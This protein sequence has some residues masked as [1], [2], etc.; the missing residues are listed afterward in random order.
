[1]SRRTR[2]DPGL[3]NAKRRRE[4]IAHARHVG[5]A[6]TDDFGR[7]LI[8]WVWQ[9]PGASDQVWSVME[10]AK[11]MGGRI[12]EAEADAIIDEATVTPRHRSADRLARWL[13]LTYDVRRALGITT[14]GAVNV[15][16]LARKEIRQIRN[17]VAKERKRRASGAIARADYESNSI[18]AKA[19]AEGVSR[20]TMYRRRRRAEQ[21]KNQPHV[22]GAG[23]A[24]FLSSEDGPVTPIG[25][26]GTSE[27]GFA[28]KEASGHPFRNGDHRAVP[29]PDYSAM[30]LELRLAA[31]CLPV[32]ENLARFA[33]AA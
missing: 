16:K 2:A 19:R 26:T 3:F 23:T 21:A 18:A 12:T 5:A 25:G 31:L 4:I 15:D 33:V 24:I 28:S 1:M 6:D 27:R 8:A 30:P 11:R 22:T 10:A 13:G 20:M 7:W 29:G 17:K 9:N 14:I 32:P